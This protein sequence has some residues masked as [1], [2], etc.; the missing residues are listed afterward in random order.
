VGPEPNVIP[1]TFTRLAENVR[2]Q[3][4]GRSLG[5]YGKRAMTGMARHPWLGPLLPA[6]AAL[7]RAP[8]V[9]QITLEDWLIEHAPVG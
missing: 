8:F 7:L 2:Q 5:S 1:A 3:I 4:D 6:R 9:V